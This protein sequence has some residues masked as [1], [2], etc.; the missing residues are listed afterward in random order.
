M[1]R[2]IGVS[3]DRAM[4]GGTSPGRA[5]NDVDGAVSE[6]SDTAVRV[7]DRDVPLPIVRGDHEIRSLP[8]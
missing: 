7:I 3:P 8:V 5:G 4:T 2:T 6:V 1:L